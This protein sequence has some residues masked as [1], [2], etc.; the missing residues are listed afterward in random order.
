MKTT[1]LYPLSPLAGLLAVAT[2][3]TWSFAALALDQPLL[4]VQKS[5]MLMTL[6]AANGELINSGEWWRIVTSQF[7]HVHAPHM[8]FNAGCIAIIGAFI[9]Q[10]YG[11]WRL[12]LVYFVGGSAGQIASVV[13]APELVSS[14]ASQALMALCGASLI[15]AAERR[16]RSFVLVVIAIQAALDV[17]VA[18]KIKPGHGFGFL[19][20][21]L[22][23]SALFF[24][25]GS[26]PRLPEPNKL[27][28]PTC[29]DA[30]G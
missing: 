15:M 10:R 12:A 29:E 19:A 16:P 17:Y 28:Q 30:R 8:L 26:Q 24:L 23:G 14:G 11:W 3:V 6:G 27:K 4:A 25:G 22:I 18:Q 5:K 7:L 13:A 1:P 20:G 21:L 9:E 2:I